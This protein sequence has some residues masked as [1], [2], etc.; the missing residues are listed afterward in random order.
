ME[1]SA[2]N[3]GVSGSHSIHA[4]IPLKNRFSVLIQT[5]GAKQ[6]IQE[7][8]IIIKNSHVFFSPFYV[9]GDS[10]CNSAS[11]WVKM[12][13][14]SSCFSFHNQT[15]Q[16]KKNHPQNPKKITKI[17][18]I[19]NTG[20]AENFF[21]PQPHFVITSVAQRHFQ[22]IFDI[23]QNCRDPACKKKEKKKKYI[24][25]NVSPAPHH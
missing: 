3:S 18:K 17:L 4:D 13:C 2:G 5:Q 14:F 11:V 22:V 23:L 9:S 7:Q 21:R 12:R 16:E 25:L 8:G 1:N 19:L 6:E 15:V 10:L 20:C 24:K